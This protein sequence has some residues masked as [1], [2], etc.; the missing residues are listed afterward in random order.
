M[1]SHWSWDEIIRDSCGIRNKWEWFCMI[2]QSFKYQWQSQAVIQGWSELW[3]ILQDLF[4]D[5]NVV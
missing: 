5:K 2:F 1:K 4:F 3:Q